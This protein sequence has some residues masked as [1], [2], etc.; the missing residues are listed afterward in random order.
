M[1]GIQNLF[2]FLCRFCGISILVSGT[3]FV[4]LLFNLVISRVLV[5]KFILSLFCV[6][7][8]FTGI[9]LQFDSVLWFIAFW[10]DLGL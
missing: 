3:L 10:F 7:V 4:M 9:L 2:L 8:C 1:R 5:V 6:T